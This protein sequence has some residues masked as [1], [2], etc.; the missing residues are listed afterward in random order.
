M[1]TDF[2]L[3][4]SPLKL[5]Y[6]TNKYPA[7][8]H[9]FIR[10]EI[11]ELERRGHSV[12]RLAIR[13]ADSAP[14]DPADRAEQERTFQVLELPLARLLFGAALGFASRPFAALRAL[15]RAL[16]LARRSDRGVVK[17]LAYWIEAL[18]LVRKL[19]GERVEHLHVH[20]GTNP[21]AVA[22]LVRELGGPPFSFTVHGPDEFDA[23]EPL[24]LD[25]KVAAARFV[26]AISDYGA[27]QLKRWARL[28]DWNK[29]HVVG[30][31]VGSAFLDAPNPVERKP[32][33]PGDGFVCVGRISAQK[34]HFVLVEALRLLRERG[35]RARLVFAG[36]GE[37][38]PSLER[39][40]DA[41][42]V[43][44]QVEITGWIDEAEIR[45][46]IRSARALVLASFAEGLPMVLME[47]LAVGRP[48][49]ATRI[50]GIPELVEHGRSGWLVTPGR[51][52]LL[53]DA[54][55]ECS[56]A[57]AQQLDGLAAHGRAAVLAAHETTREG[58]RL[59]ALFRAASAPR[60]S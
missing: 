46:R 16:Q 9:T 5:A 25:Q 37:L 26:V 19:E 29:V 45:R 12:L 54:M 20:F 23:P 6:L 1:T 17:H 32:V 22:L 27:A 15:S 36:D 4:R 8:S 24:S 35:V 31:T 52:D 34:G 40:L 51:A 11:L 39:A 2:Q 10:R 57:S 3:P 43:R 7:V 41:A 18:V 13:R 48:V 28:E 49:I 47:A 21:A 42:G 30:C 38:R 60:A 59:E 44:E 50:A 33:E 56:K 58:E 55:E 53:A 14:V